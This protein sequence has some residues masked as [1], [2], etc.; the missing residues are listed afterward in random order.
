MKVIPNT[1]DHMGGVGNPVE[2]LVNIGIS[3]IIS[4]GMGIRAI[5]WFNDEGV[6]VLQCPLGTLDEIISLYLRG[7]LVDLTKGCDHEHSHR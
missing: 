1:S 7:S 3:T 5:R 4:Q 2:N 6:R